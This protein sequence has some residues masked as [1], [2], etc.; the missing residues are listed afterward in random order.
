MSKKDYL[1]NWDPE[2]VE[3]WDKKGRS[4]ANRNL[5]ISIPA[6][7]L[8]F[9]VWFIWSAVTV[10]LDSVGFRFTTTQLFTIAAMPGLIGA[11][12]RIV[13]S[14]TVPIFGGRNWTVFSTGVLLIPAIWMGVAVQNPATSYTTMLFIG[15]LCGLGG[16]A[17]SSSMANIS[18]F[19]PKHEQGTALGLNAG[20]G[21]LGV[22]VVQFTV[23]IVVVFAVFGGFGGAGQ[24]TASGKIWLQN[25]GFIWV[26]P[27]VLVTIAAWV[28]MDNL[29]TAQTPLHEQVVIFAR[30]HMYLMTILYI[31]SFGSFIGY[32]A[33]FPLLIKTE[34]P[35][36]NPLHY[37]FL[38]P[39]IGALVRPVGGWV[40]DKIDSGAL[41]TFW[42]IV[43]MILAV[44]GVIY[45]LSDAHRSFWGFFTMFMILFATT[46]VANGSIF[47]MIGVC[48]PPKE[49]APVLGFSSA[50]AAYGAFVLPKSFGTSIRLTGSPDT[51][52]Y[53]FIVFYAVCLCITWI[54][55]S[56]KNAKTKC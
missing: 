17:F 20:L 39:M 33:A 56:R 40:S 30:K 22:S 25:A 24:M 5:W 21:N 19:Y 10:R 52:L 2:N 47:R 42:D 55:Y 14:F 34:F 44:F 29:P 49:K 50:I 26:V 45:F 3:F 15:A 18:F 38:G 16:G 9:A 13:Y 4:V 53:S 41:V 48:F 43:L 8:A 32:A 1:K 6:L 36:V 35:M 31:M 23:P 54:W 7:L 12:L 28:G 11:T 51:A 37:A 27:I 46:G